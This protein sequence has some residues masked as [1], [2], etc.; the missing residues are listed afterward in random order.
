MSMTYRWSEPELDRQT[1]R[2]GHLKIPIPILDFERSLE[3]LN[4]LHFE[5]DQ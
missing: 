1:L 4:V 5:K 3:R 2:H